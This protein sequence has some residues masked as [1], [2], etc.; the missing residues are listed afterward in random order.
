MDQHPEVK[1]MLND[2]MGAVLLDKP[3][4]VFEF[5]SE[6]FGE[7]SPENAQGVSKAGFMPMVSV[8]IHL[9]VF[10]S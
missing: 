10:W 7:L 9:S 8:S 4:D 3:G 6:H 5:A 2:F 1:A